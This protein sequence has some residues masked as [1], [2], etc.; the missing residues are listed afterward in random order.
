MD[1]GSLSER[2]RRAWHHVRIYHRKNVRRRSRGAFQGMSFFGYGKRHGRRI[3]GL[4]LATE[5]WLPDG[6]TAKNRHRHQLDRHKSNAE[7]TYLRLRTVVVKELESRQPAHQVRK[8]WHTQVDNLAPA[9]RMVKSI[10][11][12]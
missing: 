11:V 3:A 1:T 12:Q 9:R 2:L 5:P 10:F 6:T 4:T 7:G 8:L